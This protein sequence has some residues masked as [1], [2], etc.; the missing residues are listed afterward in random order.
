MEKKRLTC[1]I[2]G[3]A[4]AKTQYMKYY[5]GI[6]TKLT[7]DGAA[8]GQITTT[9]E[10]INYTSST[11]STNLKIRLNQ[12]YGRNEKSA[13]TPK[14]VYQKADCFILVVGGNKKAQSLNNIGENQI[15]Q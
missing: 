13:M 5:E 3:T 10:I 8:S 6:K 11:D 15:I 12:I 9:R 14:S 2:A 4:F 7:T 1:C